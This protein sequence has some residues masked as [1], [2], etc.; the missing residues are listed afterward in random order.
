MTRG[1]VREYAE[2]L[3]ERYHKASR[4]EKA[5]ILE[6][7]TRITGYHRKSAIRLLRG[8]GKERALSRRG[9]SKQY[10]PEV[11]EALKRV[12]ESYCQIWCWE[13]IRRAL[14]MPQ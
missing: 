2:A 14:L 9:R 6:E 1:S 3:R 13:V 7:F 11:L 5:L 12:W 8:L 10:G 4:K